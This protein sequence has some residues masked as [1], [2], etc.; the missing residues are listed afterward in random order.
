MV[1]CNKWR[2]PLLNAQLDLF[3]YLFDFRLIF[4]CVL[5]FETCFPLLFWFLFLFLFIK[6]KFGLDNYLKI[7]ELVD[8]VLLF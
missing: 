6:I 3:L 4:L 5:T 7:G 8:Y 2:L 1:S